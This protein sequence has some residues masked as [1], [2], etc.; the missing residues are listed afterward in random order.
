M[1]S[2]KI[3]ALAS[4]GSPQ[5]AKDRNILTPYHTSASILSLFMQPPKTLF[6]M[7]AN[8]K[9]DKIATFTEFQNYPKVNDEQHYS[10]HSQHCF[11]FL[12]SLVIHLGQPVK[13]LKLLVAEFFISESLKLPHHAPW[14]LLSLWTIPNW[15]VKIYQVEKNSNLNTVSSERKAYSATFR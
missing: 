1:T 3:R 6:N 11:V 15:K 12:G 5:S 2:A 13:G 8:Q 10:L 4:K 7:M 14:P 9:Y